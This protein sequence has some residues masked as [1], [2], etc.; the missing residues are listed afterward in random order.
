MHKYNS[1][2]TPRIAI[3]QEWLITLGGS[4]LVLR[5]LLRLFPDAD[6]FTLVD[7]MPA[8]DRAFLGVGKT[9]TSF[10]DRIPGIERRYRSLLP[11]FPAAV[12]SLDVSGYDIV[13]SNSHAVAKGVRTHQRQMHLCYCLSPMRYAWDLR[14]QYLREAGLSRGPK[15]LLARTMLEGLRRWDRKN[16]AGVHAFATLSHY[17][18]DRIRRAYDRS[19]TVIYPPVDTEFYVPGNSDRPPGADY[20]V[21]AGRFVSYKRTDLIAGAFRLMPDRRIVIVGDGPDAAKV[22]AVSGP[23][24]TLTGR[25][26]RAQLRSLIQGARAFIF[27]AEEDFCIAPVEAQAAGIPVIAFG[28]GGATE[29]VRG[30]GSSVPTGVFFDVQSDQ[31]IADAVRRFESLDRPMSRQAC[32]ANAERFSEERFRT[33]FQAFVSTEWSGFASRL[34]G[35]GLRS[36]RASSAV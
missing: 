14:E 21:T 23:N 20:Y 25:V 29:T 33:E 16:T 28:R 12:R 6:V 32:R 7:K 2:V 24:V 1:C 26:D 3:V 19:S 30:P 18:A 35:A 17:I 34:A 31:A 4:E 15:G 13:I 9:T 11:L 10:L 8:E 36:Q 22:R 27:A 5:E